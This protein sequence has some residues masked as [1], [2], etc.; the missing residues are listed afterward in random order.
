MEEN[1]CLNEDLSEIIF[2]LLPER[3]HTL[4]FIYYY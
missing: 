1:V 2:L 4:H 3:Q